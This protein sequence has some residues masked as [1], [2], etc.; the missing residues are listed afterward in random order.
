MRDQNEDFCQVCANVITTTIFADNPCFLAT[1]VYGDPFAPDVVALRR[2]RD[3]RLGPGATGVWLMRKV[4]DVY[5]RVGP[6]LA[7]WVTP[8]TWVG[9]LLRRAVFSP[10]A[11]RLRER[12]GRAQ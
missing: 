1:A 11:V 9:R 5:A 8:E 3:R 4:S 2:W 7:R 10:W 12:E 6:V